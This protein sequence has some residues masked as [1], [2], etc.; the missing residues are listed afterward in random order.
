MRPATN[1]PKL[2]QT[3]ARMIVPRLQM[4]VIWTQAA[5]RPEVHANPV[6]I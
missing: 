4:E 1:R 5:V 3:S 6:A 2:L